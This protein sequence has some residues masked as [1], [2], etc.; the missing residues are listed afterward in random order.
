MILTDFILSMM[1]FQKKIIS[2]WKFG[3]ITFFFIPSLLSYFSQ[4]GML[5]IEMQLIMLP[6]VLILEKNISTT[7]D[8]INIAL[9]TDKKDSKLEKFIDNI[10]NYINEANIKTKNNLFSFHI[11]DPEKMPDFE[12]K[13]RSLRIDAIHFTN[14]KK[15]VL[16][17]VCKLCK[18]YGILSTSGMEVTEEYDISVFFNL[19]NN[20]ARI[21]VNLESARAEGA[22]FSS[23]LLRLATIVG[24]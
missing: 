2:A 10:N 20:K 4:S 9:L 16:I 1:K 17:R 21:F 19:V 22:N 11:L 5:P 7:K 23:Y 3:I 24:K 8:T 14:L 12:N 15:D 13:I 6:K 18:Q